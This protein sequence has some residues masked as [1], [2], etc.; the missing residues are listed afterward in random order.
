MRKF[1]CAATSMDWNCAKALANGLGITTRVVRI[2]RSAMLRQRKYIAPLNRME[3]NL[4][5]GLEVRPPLVVEKNH[6]RKREGG[7]GAAAALLLSKYLGEQRRNGQPNRP[8]PPESHSL[9]STASGLQMGT[10][11]VFRS[12]DLNLI[13]DGLTSA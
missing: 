3:R 8:S 7:S 12:F 4:R 2:R 13:Y 6:P 10:S 1:T 5:V 9:F 11:L